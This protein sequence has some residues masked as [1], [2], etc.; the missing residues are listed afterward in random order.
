MKARILVIEDNPA[1]LALMTYLLTAFQHSVVTTCDGV[2]GLEI[3]QRELP[4]LIICDIHLPKIDGYEV[5]RQLKQSAS[6]SLRAIPLVGVTALAMPGDRDKVLAA[7]FDGYIA[8]PIEPQTFVQQ[9][10]AF[11]LAR[12]RQSP[13]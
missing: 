11:I 4:D 9:C 6:P 10:E 2:E 7:G 8:K 12:P 3:A 5:A 13:S 1:N